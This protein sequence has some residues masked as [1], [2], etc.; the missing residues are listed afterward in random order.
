MVVGNGTKLSLTQG[1][2]T[3]NGFNGMQLNGGAT[4]SGGSLTL[5][6]HGNDEAHSA[7]TATALPISNAAGFT[8]SFVYTDDGYTPGPIAFSFCIQNSSPMA[9]GYGGIANSAAVLFFISFNSQTGFGAVGQYTATS[10][11]GNVNVGSTD[12]ILV[13][14]KYNGVAGTLTET[15]LDETSHAT[16]SCTFTGVNYQAALGGSVGYVGFTGATSGNSATQ[17]I[18]NFQFNDNVLLHVA[19]PSGASSELNF[20]AAGTAPRM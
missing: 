11:T 8:A 19:V 12:P 3:L 18:S 5:T 14:L 2:W 20:A 7:F 15:L 4:V 6:T 9:T 1:P 16:A 17:V 13:N 10:A